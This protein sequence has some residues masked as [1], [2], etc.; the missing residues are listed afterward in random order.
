ME[1]DK[2]VGILISIF[3]FVCLIYIGL[4]AFKKGKLSMKI[5]GPNGTVTIQPQP[6]APAPQP[7]APPKPVQQP[8]YQAPQPVYQAPQPVQ[9]PVYQPSVYVEEPQ[10]MEGA[11]ISDV[12][13]ADFD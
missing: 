8:V 5:Q 6:V 12:N 3:I 9:Q 1:G 2:I 11:V 7:V 4:V 13:S 10:K